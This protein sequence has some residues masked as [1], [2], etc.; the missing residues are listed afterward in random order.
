MNADAGLLLSPPRVSR[1][2]RYLI[3][4]LLAGITLVGGTYYWLL[5]SSNRQIQAAMDEADRLDP[6]WQ[7][8]DLEAARAVIPDKENSALHVLAARELLPPNWQKWMNPPPVGPG[9]VESLEDLSPE[10]KLNEKQHQG[11][12]GELQKAEPAI[13]EA[14][15]VAGMPRGRYAIKWSKDVVGTLVPH[16]D[17]ARLISRILRYD[18]TLQAEAGDQSG[19][20]AS[21]AAAIYVGRSLG[22]EPSMAAQIARMYCSRQALIALERTLAQSE[23]AQRNWRRSNAFWRTKPSTLHN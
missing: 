9:L 17:S 12:A 13:A 16:V 6:G 23:R 18:A 3:V 7:F 19:A 10:I 21:V 14:S 2:R 5:G 4:V 15:R 1:R 8:A 22:D 11:L 20:L